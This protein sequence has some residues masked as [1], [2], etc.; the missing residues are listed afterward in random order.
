M[1]LVEKMSLGIIDEIV[2]T[3]EIPNYFLRSSLNLLSSDDFMKIR[4]EYTRK[5]SWA[6]LNNYWIDELAEMLQGSKCLEIYGGL[7]FL[8]YQLQKRGID[9]RCTDKKEFFAMDFNNTYT[10]VESIDA[11][12]AITSCEKDTLDYVIASWIPYKDPM[13]IRAATELAKRQ[14]RCKIVYIGELYGGCTATDRF[15]N[16]VDDISDAKENKQKMSAVRKY[17]QSWSWI[18]DD[19]CLYKPR[20]EYGKC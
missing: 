4:D 17:F 11:C 1:K 13:C 8:S 16:Y 14:P 12:K 20:K 2:S 15:F 19:I 7:G 6:I 9:I 10:E 5:V 3:K 18:Y